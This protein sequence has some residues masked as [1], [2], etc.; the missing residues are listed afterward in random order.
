MRLWMGTVLVTEMIANGSGVCGNMTE[1]G[2]M[3][4]IG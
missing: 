2:Q 4:Y 1:L 3:G